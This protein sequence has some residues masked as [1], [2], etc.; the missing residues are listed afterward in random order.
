MLNLTSIEKKK[1]KN[2]E[3]KKRTIT[4][5]KV[6]LYF[7]FV[8]ISS[9]ITSHKLDKNIEDKAMN[10]IDK[11]LNSKDMKY[12]KE[13]LNKLLDNKKYLSKPDSSEEYLVFKEQINILSKRIMKPL[14]KEL[15]VLKSKLSTL[16]DSII[17]NSKK[18]N[19]YV[20]LEYLKE[21]IK[22]LKASIK[23]KELEIEN[24]QKN[25]EKI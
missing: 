6:V 18:E 3:N 23:D 11:Q 22:K 15:K 21:K 16:E 8:I 7:G 12:E 9:V 14:T 13:R 10:L 1:R 4:I 24:Y 5:I 2:M 20:N 25:I 17:R 19:L